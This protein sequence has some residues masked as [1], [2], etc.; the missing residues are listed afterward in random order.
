VVSAFGLERVHFLSLPFAIASGWSDAAHG[1]MGTHPEYKYRGFLDDA[2]LPSLRLKTSIGCY[3]WF[4][5]IRG[6]RR[7]FH[8]AHRIDRN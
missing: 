4:L 2:R 5:N 6:E 1:L 8:G 3:L 7:S